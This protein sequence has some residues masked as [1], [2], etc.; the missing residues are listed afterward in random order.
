MTM[1]D[2]PLGL[3]HK[4]SNPHPAPDSVSEEGDGD[5]PREERSEPK[6]EPI[7]AG[8]E[9][10][11]SQKPLFSTGRETRSRRLGAER[12]VSSLDAVSF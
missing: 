8:S 11:R 10:G 7:E 1:K 3:R 6:G 4:G 9:P 12:G 2:R 5:A